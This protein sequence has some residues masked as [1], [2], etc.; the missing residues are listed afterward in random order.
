MISS[1]YLNN[2]L[3]CIHHLPFPKGVPIQSV[4]A[5]T[6]TKA[7]HQLRKQWWLATA[8]AGTTTFLFWQWLRGAWVTQF[9]N[10]WLGIT[11]V[12]TTYALWVVWQHLPENHRQGERDLLPTF[13]PGNTL[14]LLRTLLLA[15][16][17]GFFFSPWPDGVL[18][19]LPVL[20]YTTAV[21]VD[22]F[23]GYAARVSNQATQLGARL[24]MTFDGLGVMLV[25]L[26]AVWYGQLPW[27]YV[28][29]GLA[30]YFFVWGLWLRRQLGWPV[31]DMPPS[32]HRR[33]FAGFQ[34]G[35]LSA[36]L[37]PIVPAGGAAVAGTIFAAATAVSFLRDWFVVIGWLNPESTR[38]RQWQRRLFVAIKWWL[39]VVVRG[40]L[41][42]AVWLLWQQAG[43][44]QRSLPITDG[45][46]LWGVAEW[47]VTPL[48]A[49]LLLGTGL[50]AVGIMPRLFA[51]LLVFPLAFWVWGQ[52]LTATSGMVTAA[53][54]IIVVLGAGKW[55]LWPVEEPFVERRFGAPKG[56][57]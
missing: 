27:W 16:M 25:S 11:A 24:D 50:A 20:F 30:R 51:L 41:V 14:T 22:F 42:T 54:M 9:A 29:L 7:L 6:Q 34:M 13:G 23:D 43:G 48:T 37:W 21:I 4:A 17:A 40:I 18:A 3:T 33:M 1:V 10:K 36:V 19:W 44:G 46:Q 35:F 32:I 8:V 39:P 45:L 12:C 38:Y 28:I 53:A 47:L 15:M 26:L 49:A 52:G 55:A 56:N 57:T 31:H 2:T 5:I